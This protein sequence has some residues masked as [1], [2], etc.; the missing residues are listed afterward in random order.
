MMASGIVWTPNVTMSCWNR[1][2]PKVRLGRFS[3]TMRILIAGGF[4]FVGGRLAEHFLQ[5]GHQI[6]LGSRNES[7]PPDWLPQAEVAQIKWNDDCDLESSCEGVDV[8]IHA[9]GMNVQDC[10]AD[11]ATALDF[12]GV[13]TA[14]LVEAASRA[15]V[16][17]FIYLSTAHIYAS[18]LVSTITEETLPRNLHPYATSHLAGEH[19][20]LSASSRG[21]TSRYRVTTI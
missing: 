8:I 20:V 12:N 6:V 11:P 3:L 9:A 10:A 18:L 5:A 1:S 14:N 4:G 16:K 21:D 19:A 13:A 7:N 15:G 2:G 17:K